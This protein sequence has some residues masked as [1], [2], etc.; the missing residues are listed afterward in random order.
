MLLGD[1]GGAVTFSFQS[2]FLGVTIVSQVEKPFDGL[3][4]IGV[5]EGLDG[6]TDL[7]FFFI[8]GFPV[9]QFFFVLNDQEV[10]DVLQDPFLFRGFRSF[11]KFFGELVFCDFRDKVFWRITSDYFE[12]IH[13]VGFA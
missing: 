4:R 3:I 2:S 5:D 11:L 10:L 12:Q 6:S 7:P 1:S 13:F 8:Q 9:A